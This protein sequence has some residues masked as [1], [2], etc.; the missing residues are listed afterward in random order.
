M[1]KVA[2]STMRRPPLA[3]R[4]VKNVLLV[5]LFPLAL[6]GV[7]DILESPGN[8][9]GNLSIV[10]RMARACQKLAKGDIHEANKL[11]S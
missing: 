2:T 6:S 7:M 4:A 3:T 9:I 1:R 10:L 11:I 5:L 8:G